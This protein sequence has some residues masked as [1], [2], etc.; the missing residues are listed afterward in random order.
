MDCVITYGHSIVYG[1]MIIN[2]S[3]HVAHM[4]DATYV[5]CSYVQKRSLPFAIFSNHS[6]STYCTI[7]SEVPAKHV[8]PI[9]VN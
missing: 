1:V 3:I 9:G 2:D 4:Y 6:E 7:G 5:I 8:C